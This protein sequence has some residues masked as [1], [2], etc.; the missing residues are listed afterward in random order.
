[1]MLIPSFS[2]MAQ[3]RLG[4]NTTNPI[5]TLEVAGSS[6]QY[7]RVHSSTI[8]STTGMEFFRGSN[9]LI[10]RDWKFENDGGTL[11]FFKSDDDF[12]SD[13][14]EVMRIT[15]LTHTGLGTNI[16]ATRLHINDGTLFAFGGEGYLKI[17]NHSSNNIAFDNSQILAFNNGSPAALYLQNKGGTTHFGLNG[18]NTYMG[19]GGGVVR[20]GSSPSTAK[21][22]IEDDNFQLYLRNAA[23]DINDWYIGASRNTWLAGDNQLLF[24]PTSSSDDAVLRLMNVTENDGNNAPVMIHSSETNT[25]LLDG[26]EI[27][28]RGTPLYINHN[29]DETTN[30]NP[31]GGKVGI[32]TT[33]PQAMLHV[34]TASG[35]PLTLQNGGAKWHIAPET[36]GNNNLGFQWDGINGNYAEVDGA[37]GQWMYIS[38]RNF[39]E[40]IEPLSSVIEKLK[41]LVMYSY[42]FKNDPHKTSSLGVIAQ[43]VEP[44]FPEMVKVTDN[45]YGVAYSQLA[46]VGIKA[47][48]EQQAIIDSLREKIQQLKKD[49]GIP[50]N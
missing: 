44:L 4:I 11:K 46:V 22:N 23:D 19:I 6:N 42:T 10:G 27:D 35:I 48:Q 31:S 37:T 47:I 40:N 33:N 50:S 39:K 29:S 9:D 20:V 17:G 45:Q 7:I 26:N 14:S 41:K 15:S 36:F 38:D 43:E 28:T 24:S 34:Y 18:G 21:L 12:Q 30:I 49:A 32:G 3:Q 2:L 1:M 5:R 8:G 13:I 25:I 16:P